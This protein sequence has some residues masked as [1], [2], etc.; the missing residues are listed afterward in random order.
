LYARINLN[1]VFKKKFHSC[2]KTFLNA[3]PPPPPRDGPGILRL[4]HLPEDL[5]S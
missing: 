5:R 1:I 2:S 3:A 4:Y